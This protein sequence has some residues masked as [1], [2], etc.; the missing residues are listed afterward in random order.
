MF[1]LTNCHIWD[2]YNFKCQHFISMIADPF[3]V[4]QNFRNMFIYITMQ[5]TLRHVCLIYLNTKLPSLDNRKLANVSLYLLV[6]ACCISYTLLSRNLYQYLYYAICS[7]NIKYSN[8]VSVFQETCLGIFYQY[9][10]LI[11]IFLYY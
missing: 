9:Y 3:T 5:F 6:K 8:E 1:I 7:E 11:R 4:H 10:T 2:Y